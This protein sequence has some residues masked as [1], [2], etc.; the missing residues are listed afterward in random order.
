MLNFTP[1]YTNP[2][3][4][5]IINT[6]QRNHIMAVL[7]AKSIIKQSFIH[8]RRS[9]NKFEACKTLQNGYNKANHIKERPNSPY[10]F[11]TIISTINSPNP[12]CEVRSLL[13]NLISIDKKS[14]T[15][16]KNLKKSLKTKKETKKQ[17]IF[18]VSD[19]I[20]RKKKGLT[21]SAKKTLDK[22]L[23]NAGKFE[24]SNKKNKARCFSSNGKLT[25]NSKKNEEI[26]QK[27]EELKQKNEE[28]MLKNPTKSIEEIVK[29][30]KPNE[31]ET[32]E[33]IKNVKV[34]FETNEIPSIKKKIVLYLVKHKILESEEFESVKKD[35]LEKLEE[36]REELKFIVEEIENHIFK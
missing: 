3:G 22:L 11:S 28:F 17:K 24:L 12:C 18:Y 19:F 23:P 33:L 4:K 25:I 26:K 27:N 21:L 31:G 20:A 30:K 35:L 14:I 16:I 32:E 15:N 6:L 2:G 29:Y 7:N 13:R 34:L 36:N 1:I 8:T 5:N 9:F 10:Q